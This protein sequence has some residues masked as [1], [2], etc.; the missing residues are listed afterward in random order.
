M[1][2]QL[3]SVPTSY[4][5]LG[6]WAANILAKKCFVAML[7]KLRRRIHSLS[8]Y[9]YYWNLKKGFDLRTLSVVQSQF[10]S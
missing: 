9:G 6:K 7:V 2:L 10:Y 3:Y 5:G 4:L 1:L 8:S